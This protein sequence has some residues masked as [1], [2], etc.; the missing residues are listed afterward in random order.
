MASTLTKIK[1]SFKYVLKNDSYY[2]ERWY[3]SQILHHLR[4]IIYIIINIKR[5]LI[6]FN[7]KAC[8]QQ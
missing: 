7:D 2:K 6:L 3:I 1:E 8:H 5:L 4:D